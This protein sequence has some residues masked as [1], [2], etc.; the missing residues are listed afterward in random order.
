MSCEVAAVDTEFRLEFASGRAM[1]TA[2]LESLHL[3]HD[4]G[5]RIELIDR[6]LDD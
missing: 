6:T 2:N 4:G 3:L 1:M 5:I